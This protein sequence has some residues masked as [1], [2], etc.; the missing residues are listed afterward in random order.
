MRLS[1]YEITLR[2]VLYDPEMWLKT[3]EQIARWLRYCR[4]AHTRLA[5]FAE[6]G[7]DDA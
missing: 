1:D 7:D 6:S 5:Q 3:P 4:D 2:R